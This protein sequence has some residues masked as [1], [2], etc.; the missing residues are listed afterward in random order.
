M[1]IEII[2][3][4]LVFLRGVIIILPVIGTVM[5]IVIFLMLILAVKGRLVKNLITKHLTEE[6]INAEAKET[7]SVLRAH[8]T[9]LEA[10]KE[11]LIVENQQYKSAKSRTLK[12]WGEM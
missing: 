11:R 3:S 8:I 7:I 9:F 12:I 6:I 2:Q 1:D 10:E 5:G 4:L